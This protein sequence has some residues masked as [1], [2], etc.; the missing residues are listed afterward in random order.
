MKFLLTP[1]LLLSLLFAGMKAIAQAPEQDCINGI[2]VCN[3]I[4]TQTNSYTGTGAYP[5]EL[6]NANWGCLHSGE[7]N[8]VWYIVNVT[9]T[10][11]LG[12]NITPVN[13]ADD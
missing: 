7:R 12:M 8:D 6:T 11:T 4:Y 5:A 3:Y 13:L 9:T 2:R 10:G 1:L